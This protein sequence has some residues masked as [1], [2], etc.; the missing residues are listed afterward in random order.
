MSQAEVAHMFA[1][2]WVCFRA[3]NPQTRAPALLPH[4]LMPSIP[5]AN[6]QVWRNKEERAAVKAA[7][8]AK[9]AAAMPP[10]R[11]P[12]VRTLHVPLFPGDAA[13]LP[14]TLP[15]G[16]PPGAS[17]LQVGVLPPRTAYVPG[18]QLPT[19]PQKRPLPP[20]SVAGASGLSQYGPDTPEAGEKR[21]KQQRSQDG[22]P[23]FGGP[24]EPKTLDAALAK[25]GRG[26]TRVNLHPIVRSTQRCGHCKA[27]LNPGWKK[28]CETR[29]AEMT[30]QQAQFAPPPPAAE[31]PL[32][33]GTAGAQHMHTS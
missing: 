6:K 28:P 12:P 20:V 15:A 27:C 22:T 16:A 8:A 3:F 26:R 18:R 4:F 17:S 23:R 31:P 29:R 25:S 11:P 19:T 13:P 30:V 2:G 5:S 32:P 10:P 7:K 33:M 9:R 1:H 24:N 14:P 21:Q